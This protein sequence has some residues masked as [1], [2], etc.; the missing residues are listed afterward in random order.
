MRVLVEA[1][2]VGDPVNE[3]PEC[4]SHLQLSKKVQAVLGSFW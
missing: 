1:E 2:S 4:S 3:Q